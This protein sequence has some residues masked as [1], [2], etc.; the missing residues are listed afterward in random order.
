MTDAG[1]PITERE[2]W[3]AIQHVEMDYGCEP[4]RLIMSIR[5]REAGRWY[6]LQLELEAIWTAIEHAELPRWR[7]IR[8][9]WL[10]ERIEDRFEHARAMRGTFGGVGV[11][12]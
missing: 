7:W 10:K 2:F 3:R 8:R 11:P 12:E 9:R 4:D 6:C 1:G 5:T